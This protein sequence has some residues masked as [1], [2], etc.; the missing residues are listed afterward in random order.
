MNFEQPSIS[1]LEKSEGE[2]EKNIGEILD[3][4]ILNLNEV[5]VNEAIR[6]LEFDKFDF[7]REDDFIEIGNYNQIGRASCR[8][9]V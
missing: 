4:F 1:P 6:L 9:R 3:S 5:S 8:E 2:K 7:V